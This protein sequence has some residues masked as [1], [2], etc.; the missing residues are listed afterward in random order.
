MEDPSLLLNR[1]VETDPIGSLPMLMPGRNRAKPGDFMMLDENKQWGPADAFGDHWLQ[2][3]GYQRFPAGFMMEWGT[4][5][6]IQGYG[7]ASTGGYAGYSNT[8]AVAVSF[9]KEF[10]YMCFGVYGNGASNFTFDSNYGGA[11][12]GGYSYNTT[13]PSAGFTFTNITRF[14]FNVHNN[15]PIDMACRWFAVGH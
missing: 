12:P 13:F 5:G 8:N 9:Y 15:T 2:P 1:V 4:T 14:G 10:Q 11:G 7:F 6:V 3:F